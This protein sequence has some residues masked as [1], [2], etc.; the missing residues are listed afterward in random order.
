MPYYGMPVGL[1][2]DGETVEKVGFGYS[3]QILTRLL[4]V[5]LGCDGAIMTDWEVVNDNHVGD[6]VLP[7]R[8]G[9]AWNTSTRRGACGR[10]AEVDGRLRISSVIDE[11][12]MSPCHADQEPDQGRSRDDDRDADHDED[13]GSHQH[14]PLPPELVRDRPGDRADHDGG[15]VSDQVREERADDLCRRGAR[16]RHFCGSRAALSQVFQRCKG[17]AVARRHSSDVAD[18]RGMCGQAIALRARC[19]STRAS[20]PHSGPRQPPCL[21]QALADHLRDVDT[22]RYMAAETPET[23]VTS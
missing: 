19:T 3:K 7:A 10:W 21:K 18:E 23:A 1:T 8:A 13:S 16:R 14:G 17:Q 22:P 11:S 12:G 6:Q 20:S 4:R 9:G 15:T 2:I 5:R